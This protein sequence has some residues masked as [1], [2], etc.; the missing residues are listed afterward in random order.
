VTSGIA[1]LVL[2]EGVPMRGDRLYTTEAV[3]AIQERLA[4]GDMEGVLMTMYR[5]LVELPPEEIEL[6]RGQTDAW[7]ARLR[8][9]PTLARELTAE[10]GYLFRPARFRGM[11]TP[12][13]L[14]VGGDSPPRELENARG[15]VAALA[16][17]RVITL[18]GQQHGAMY[19]APDVFIG[20]VSAF[21]EP[22]EEARSR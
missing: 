16:D 13:A 8:N 7:A 15:V 5:D 6:L 9:A 22:E 18:P 4:A 19:A 12:T 2:Y 21:L 20:V 11:R 3:E 17:A 14:L 1:R 10:A